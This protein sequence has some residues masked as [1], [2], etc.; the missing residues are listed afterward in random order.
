M[1]EQWTKNVGEI[2][3]KDINN[4]KHPHIQS[5]VLDDFNSSSGQIYVSLRMKPFDMPVARGRYNFV[6]VKRWF[7]DTVN[8][9]K[10]LIDIS[11]KVKG[12]ITRHRDIVSIDYYDSPKK[13]FVETGTPEKQ[14][15]GYNRN[16]II[17]S[18]Y[19]KGWSPEEY[20]KMMRRRTDLKGNEMEEPLPI[21]DDGKNKKLGEFGLLNPLKNVI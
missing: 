19:S 13:T 8:D 20:N 7:F 2:L 6:S 3:V 21:F 18:Y 11:A 10:I 14:F 1:S 17:L 15:N 9:K 12:I 5:A 16:S 4:L